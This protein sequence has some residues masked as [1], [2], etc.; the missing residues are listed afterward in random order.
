MVDELSAVVERTLDQAS[1][2]IG[3]HRISQCISLHL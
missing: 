1:G 3:H 2:Y